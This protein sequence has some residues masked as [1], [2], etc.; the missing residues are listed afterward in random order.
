MQKARR[1]ASRISRS[2]HTHLHRQRQR[3]LL[4][5]SLE[6]RDLLATFTVTSVADSGPGT[7][8]QA[9]LDANAHPNSQAAPASFAVLSAPPGGA[10]SDSEAYG[11]DG[12]NT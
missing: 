2:R 1:S 8:R 6:S 4:L 10:D 12:N 5:E 3:R 11:I 7:L 9:I